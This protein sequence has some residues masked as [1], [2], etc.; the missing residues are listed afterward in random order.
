MAIFNDGNRSE[1]FTDRRQGNNGSPSPS[2]ERRQFGNS[3][4]GLS[5]QAREIAEAIDRYKLKNRRRYVTYEEMLCVIQDLGYV[6]QHVI[7]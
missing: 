3:H 5:P 4:V 7:A 2:V 6:K 1:D